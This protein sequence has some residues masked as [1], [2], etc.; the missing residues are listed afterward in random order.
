MSN[1]EQ[2]MREKA[3]EIMALMDE[4]N[5]LDNIDEAY[6]RQLLATKGDQTLERELIHNKRVIMRDVFDTLGVM[7]GQSRT[8]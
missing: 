4:I 3:R 2:E 5:L 7:G 1:S 6:C 8:S